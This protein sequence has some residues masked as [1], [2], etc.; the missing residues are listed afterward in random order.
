MAGAYL[1]VFRDAAWVRRAVRPYVP[2]DDVRSIGWN[3]TA[4]TGAAPS[5]YV[6]LARAAVML[7]CD[8]ASRRISARAGAAPLAAAVE[9][10][11]LLALSAVGSGAKVGLLLATA[12]PTPS[13]RRAGRQARAA[14][15]AGLRARGH[16]A[17][18]RTAR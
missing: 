4:R 1:S 15:P 12:A 11:A 8:I 17:R 7:L 3:V 5:R 14:H 16:E 18:G 6:E 13:S 9:L 2:G 10:C